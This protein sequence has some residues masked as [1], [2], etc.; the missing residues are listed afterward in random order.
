MALAVFVLIIF[1]SI[2]IYTIWDI[3]SLMVWDVDYIDSMWISSG[4]EIER[5]ISYNLNYNLNLNFNLNQNLIYYVYIMH[6]V[7]Y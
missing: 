4:S 3:A 6:R 2:I 7:I 5:I 1:Y